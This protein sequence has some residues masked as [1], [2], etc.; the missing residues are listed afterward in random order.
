M[1]LDQIG[2]CAHSYTFF[3]ERYCLQKERY[4]EF[5]NEIIRLKKKYFGI[6]D[7]LCGIEQD[8]YS[9]ISADGFDYVIGSVHYL[10]IDSDTFFPLDEAPSIFKNGCKKYFDGDYFSLAN[11][12]YSME[13]FFSVI[14]L[15]FLFLS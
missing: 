9:D 7:V 10:K 4:S 14:Y 15:K 3:D 12:Y 11:L 2:I 8:F 13:L 6:I 5:K 1:W